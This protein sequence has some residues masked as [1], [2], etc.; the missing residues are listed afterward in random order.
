MKK[1]LKILLL[2]ALIIFT[3]ANPKVNKLALRLEIINASHYDIIS[4]KG[5]VSKRCKLGSKKDF[6]IG[7]DHYLG[8]IINPNPTHRTKLKLNKKYDGVILERVTIKYD[9]PGGFDYQKTYD[10]GLIM[11]HNSVI[12]LKIG[13]TDMTASIIR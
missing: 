13:T 8:H 4:I 2:P 10:C 12:R 7:K 6:I 1:L 9:E 5:I 11:K 3:S